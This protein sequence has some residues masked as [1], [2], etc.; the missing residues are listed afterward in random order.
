MLELLPFSPTWL[1]V[2]LCAVLFY[3]FSTWS[4][5]TFKDLGI[6]GPKPVPLV[7]NYLSYVKGV[8][9]FDKAC[10]KKFNKVWGIYEGRQPILLVGDLEL[11]KDITVKEANTF[12]NRRTFEGQG[13]LLSNGISNLEDADW[14]RV[15]SAI[16]PTFSSGKLKQMAPVVEKCADNFVANLDENAKN[17]VQ[18]NLKDLS[19]AYTMDV[20]SGTAFGVDVDSLHNPDHPFVANAK[21]LFDFNLFN[22]V[23]IIFFLFPKMANIMEKLGYSLF[24][25]PVTTFFS[26]AVDNAIDMRKSNEDETKRVD[27]LQ[28]MLKAHNKELDGKVPKDMVK[29]GVSKKEIKGNAMLF[30][31]VGYDTTAN[32]ISLTAYNLAV[33]QEVQDRVIDEV[34]TVSQK[35]GQ[36][37]YEAVNEMHYLDMCVSE[38]LRMFPAAQ[39]FDRVCKEDTEVK[40]LHIPAGTIVTIPAY[41]I[42]HDPELWPEP[43][44]FRPERFSKEEK[45]ARDPYAYLPFGSGPRNCV[46]MRLALLELKFALAKALQ[47]FRFVT[48]DKTVVPIRI[49]NTLG[50][51][52]E[53]GVWLK[54]EART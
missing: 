49:K 6:P 31:L 10:Y 7:G 19:G 33:H 18:F 34:N 37:D 53:G 35:R 50:N 11:V 30:W 25:K 17:D 41:A 12:T 45:E 26:A 13:E 36:L 3:L 24:S 47:K 5:S 52:I 22:P 44:N 16:S 29:H 38:T 32:T 1:L 40:G 21:K 20:I 4:Y 28:L 51:Q 14:K 48:S 2:G 39:R 8:S 42:H 46:G 23:V 9:T 54:V 27:F 43:E 15:R